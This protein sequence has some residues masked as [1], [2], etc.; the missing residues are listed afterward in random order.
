MARMVNK[1]EVM[2][3]T[4]PAVHNRVYKS[5]KSVIREKI[6]KDMQDLLQLN[7]VNHKKSDSS[8]L[9]TEQSLAFRSQFFNIF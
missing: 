8:V 6:L 4:N 5:G 9:T 7:K 3:R 2:V 1:I